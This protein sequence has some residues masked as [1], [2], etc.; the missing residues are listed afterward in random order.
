MILEAPHPAAAQLLANY[1][2]TAEGQ[3]AIN[4]GFGAVMKDIPGTYFVAPRTTKLSE[5]TPK[6]VSD[7]ITYW[8]SLFI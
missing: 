4:K 7:Y 3:E 6:K 1:M 8:N 5:F 2:V